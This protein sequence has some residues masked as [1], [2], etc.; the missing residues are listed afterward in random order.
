MARDPTELDDERTNEN[1]AET[2]DAGGNTTLL[3]RRS[4][5]KAAGVASLVGAG[6]AGTG[7]GAAASEYDVIEVPA[8]EL[9]EYSLDDGETFENKLIDISAEGAEARINAVGNDWTVRNVGWHGVWDTTNREAFIYCAVENDSATGR[10]EN[11]YMGDGAISND[12]PNS[13]NGIY[14][15]RNHAGELTISNVNIQHVADNAVYASEAGRSGNGPVIIKD[16]YAANLQPAA[17]RVGSDGSRVENCVAVDAHRGVWVRHH[18]A[19]VRDCDLSGCAISDLYVGEAGLAVDSPTCTVHNTRYGTQHVSSDATLEG[20]SAGSAQRTSPEEVE[21]VPVTAT[22]AASGTSGSSDG[23]TGGTDDESTDGTDAAD[24]LLAFVT[25]PDA[26]Y[27]EYEFTV[28]GA[29]ELAEADYESPSGRAIGANG[30]DTIEES[31]GTTHVSGLTGGGY[32]DAFR[33]SGPVTSID[34]DQPE[35]MWVELDGEEIPPEEVIDTTADGG[36]RPSNAIT[37]DGTST[38][39]PTS[40]SF[41]VTG[42]VEKASHQDASIDDSDTIDG[43]A[44]EGS[45]AGWKDAYWFSG[46]IDDFWLNGD[47]VVDVEYDAR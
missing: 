47:A 39:D 1:G 21:G 3:D 35:V 6:I 18:S 28:D 12:Y 25:D 41:R 17:W 29:V 46:S 27:A 36:D 20:S 11:C 22:E 8:G 33:V 34:I 37:I 4:Y 44:V 5:L 38:D 10:I 7:S 9:W 15:N 16:S 45:V 30:N 2:A 14:V 32:G 13:P 42:T 31:N 40:Y 26:R 19:E 23:S 43:T 24:R